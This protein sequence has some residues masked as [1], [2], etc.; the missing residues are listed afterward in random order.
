MLLKL[1]RSLKQT[2]PFSKEIHRRYHYKLRDQIHAVAS[3]N[4]PPHYLDYDPTNTM[5]ALLRQYLCSY[6]F[7]ERGCLSD[8]RATSL[9]TTRFVSLGAFT[10]FSR[11]S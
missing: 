10:N 1:T 6:H 8:K 7:E 9:L 2:P 5:S 3:G 4:Q 11:L